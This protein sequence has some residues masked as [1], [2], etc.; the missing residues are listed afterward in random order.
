MVR[1]RCG[2]A[3]GGSGLKNLCHL[4]GGSWGKY[5]VQEDT[6][7]KKK[8]EKLRAGQAGHVSVAYL[9]IWLMIGLPTQLE[10]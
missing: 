2:S 4:Y 1:P 8:R 9:V 5:E 3:N 7:L 10:K 6:A